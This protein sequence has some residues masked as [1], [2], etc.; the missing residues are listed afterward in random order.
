MASRRE[1]VLDAVAALWRTALPDGD[2]RRNPVGAPRVGPGGLVVIRDGDPGPPDID[3]SPLR[4]NY[5]HPIPCEVMAVAPDDET[6]AEMVDD[7]LSRFGALLQADRTLG[8]L[9]D[10]L[11]VEAPTSDDITLSGAQA[12]R[13]AD[14]FVV[15]QYATANP[16]T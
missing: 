16:L 3:L 6:G 5:S 12:T 2:V 1:Q 9:V 7:M 13:L 14:I 11:D 10:F 15:A 8:G 4:Y